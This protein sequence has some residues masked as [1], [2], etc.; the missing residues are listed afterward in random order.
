MEK[1]EG[2]GLN[3]A[4]LEIFWRFICCVRCAN[5]HTVICPD[6]PGRGKSAYLRPHQYYVPIYVQVLSAICKRYSGG[7]N[8]LIGAGWG[9]L[10]AAVFAATSAAKFQKFIALDMPVKW[11]LNGGAEF[12]AAIKEANMVFDNK[13]GVI[14]YLQSKPGFT[15]LRSRSQINYLDG[16]IEETSGKFRFSFDANALQFRGV[17]K[18]Q[19]MKCQRL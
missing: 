16:R 17:D 6:M 13:S 12:Q 9:S 15:R 18:N 2:N 19:S 10:I 11:S 4:I 3:I 1:W 7:H 8:I 14:A 5:G